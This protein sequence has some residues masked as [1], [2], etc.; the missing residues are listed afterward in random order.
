MRLKYS[1]PTSKELTFHSFHPGAGGRDIMRECIL[2]EFPKNVEK[3][4]LQAA[5]VECR[6]HSLNLVFRTVLAKEAWLDR[7]QKHF[8]LVSR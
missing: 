1:E 4:L 7:F 6:E 3:R 5:A 8:D 2:G